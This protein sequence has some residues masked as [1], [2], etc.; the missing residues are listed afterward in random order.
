[1]NN[2]ILSQKQLNIVLRSV[3][4]YYFFNAPTI[5][6]NKDKGLTVAQL[7]NGAIELATSDL[8]EYKEVQ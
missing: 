5:K 6:N 4:V 1:M 3:E 7:L 8:K 2:Q